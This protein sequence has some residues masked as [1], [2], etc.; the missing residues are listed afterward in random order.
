MS[1]HITMS[2][3]NSKIHAENLEENIRHKD[4]IID[5]ILQDLQKTS[6]QSTHH[7]L[8]ELSVDH[9]EKSHRSHL[10][11]ICLQLLYPILNSKITN[12][13]ETLF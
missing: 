11:Q 4:N 10:L 6:S 1:S 9:Q 13:H 3:E 8:A 12:G 5:Q 7:L 2:N